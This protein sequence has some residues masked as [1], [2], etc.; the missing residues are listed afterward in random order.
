MSKRNKIN[1]NVK[2]VWSPICAKRY[3]LIFILMIILVISI[4]FGILIYK[5]HTP[6]IQSNKDIKQSFKISNFVEYKAEYKNC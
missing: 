2:F 4:S 5:F 1:N 3:I 6:S